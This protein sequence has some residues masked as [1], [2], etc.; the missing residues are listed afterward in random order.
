[1]A[2]LPDID[3]SSVSAIA[4][5]NAIDQGGVSSISPAET[6]SASRVQN[7]TT[8]DNGV[9]GEF[10]L[11]NERKAFFRVK[12]DGWLV[13]Y[14]S[15]SQSFNQGGYGDNPPRGPWDVTEG[16][17]QSSDAWNNDNFSEVVKNDLERTIN[18]LRAELSNGGSVTYSPSDVGLYDYRYQDA[19]G[20]TVL[21]GVVYADQNQWNGGN[22]MG[23]Q[24]TSNTEIYQAVGLGNVEANYDSY[25]GDG[26]NGSV[27]FEGTTICLADS[28]DTNEFVESYGA[29]DLQ[30][31]GL[32]PNS[33]TEYQQ[34]I[35]A[36]ISDDKSDDIY[37]FGTTYIIWG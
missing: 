36:S 8:Y 17:T 11:R 9:E 7:Y 14:I 6:T 34:E 31:R 22:N 25:W 1:M 5:F 29:I 30:S 32:I 13:A 21:S 18:D 15:D 16:W 26:G 19:T 10:D 3:T 27:K 35:S 33:G 37:S 28:D 2:E 12:T 23:F 4:F 24:Y 20:I